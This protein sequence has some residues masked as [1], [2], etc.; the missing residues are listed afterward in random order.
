MT[1]PNKIIYVL[2]VLFALILYLQNCGHVSANKNQSEEIKEL[3]K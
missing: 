3:K 2:A 1:K